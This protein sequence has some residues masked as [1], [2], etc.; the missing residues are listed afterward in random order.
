[1]A[2]TEK[3]PF[4][5]TFDVDATRRQLAK[6]LD[7]IAYEP[8]R[9][10]L[11][12]Y[13]SYVYGKGYIGEL[14]RNLRVLFDAA[15]KA[16]AFQLFGS[17]AEKL[18][19]ESDYA[20]N[21]RFRKILEANPDKIKPP[22]SYVELATALRFV[23]SNVRGPDGKPRAVQGTTVG[24]MLSMMEVCKKHHKAPKESVNGTVALIQDLVSAMRSPGF[25]QQVA[26][27]TARAAARKR[28][29]ASTTELSQALAGVLD[30][31]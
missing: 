4:L 13:E 6:V 22:P 21:T 17:V 20:Y 5:E 30:A 15:T 14:P 31:E 7:N 29:S 16:K 24:L 8:I 26:V 2:E 12:G 18:K 27:E 10:D 23:H 25:A 11:P 3:T 28:T 19:G 9:P 1:M